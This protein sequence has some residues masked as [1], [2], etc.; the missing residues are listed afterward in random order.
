MK[1]HWI[2]TVRHYT[3]GIYMG[4]SWRCSECGCASLED[5]A[6]F[7]SY[8]KFCHNCGVEM[9]N[10]PKLVITEITNQAKYS[11]E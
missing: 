8:E 4:E 2:F 5:C 6:R 1:G 9:L 7:P 3:N 10:E 11:W